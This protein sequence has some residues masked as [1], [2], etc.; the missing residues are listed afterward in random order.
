M[1]ESLPADLSN[2]DPADAWRPWQ[3]A[4]GEWNRKWVAHLY[5][6]A[7]FGATPAEIDQALAQGPTKTLDRILTG[8]PDQADRL[9]LLTESGKFYT[10]PA[11]LRV[12]W[13][14][15]MTEG[16][17]PLREK[18]ALF[19]HN[20]FATSY[21]KVRS[22]S[23]MYEQNVT[24]R[25]HALG[26]FRPFLL[27]MSK[28]PA[29]LVWLD[30]NRN[31]K[32]APNENYAR[33]VMELFSLGVGNNNYTEKDIQEAARA[34]TGWH[35]DAEVKQFEFNREL[36]DDG[37]K[38]VF[39]K[40]GRWTGEDVVRLCCD[41]AACPKFL[42]SKL[43]TFLVSEEAPPKGLLAPLADQFRKSDYD[44]AALV[45]TVL[46]SRLFFSAH[47]YRKRVKWPVECALGAVRT[48]VATRVPLADL[49]EPLAKMGQALFSPPNVKGWRTGT[50]WLNSAT[51]LSRNNFAEKVATGR[52]NQNPR[53]GSRDEVFT[54]VGEPAKSDG[55]KAEEPP[56]P[57]PDAK[58]DVCAAVYATKPKDVAAV[59]KR[60]GEL[61][62]GEA[63]TPAQAKKIETFLL[64][65][66]PAAP[67]PADPKGPA[68]KGKGAKIAASSPT[69]G[70]SKDAPKEEKKDAKKEPPQPLDP[71]DVKLDSADFKARVREAYHAMMCLPEYQLS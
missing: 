12:W 13:L 58:F 49:L 16:G 42:V 39:G 44:I 67:A 9:E 1:A 69:A 61:L 6:R 56:P 40:T 21:A 47:A 71:K 24:I 2:V 45:R 10:E 50:D 11:N 65:P 29:M 30:S 17:H 35:H 23:L 53:P 62:Y 55:P 28:D 59:V 68:A 54:T 25:K 37:T 14:Y 51:L 27:D 48:A 52:W 41:H 3:P 32:G 20:H 34:L 5:R 57:P 70:A 8:E 22:T 36:H 4:A 19:W 18:L 15:A 31:V 63:V 43:Y 33:E 46:G 60:M 7:G 64:T 66:G 38:T 26:K